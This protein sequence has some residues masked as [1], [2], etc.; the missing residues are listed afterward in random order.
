MCTLPPGDLKGPVV[1]FARRTAGALAGMF[2]L[3][4]P[5]QWFY[6]VERVTAVL[7]DKTCDPFSARKAID[8]YWVLGRISHF[9]FPG[10][11]Q[12]AFSHL[13][14]ARFVI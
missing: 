1:V 8:Q 3:E 2:P 9:E 5:E 6:F 11:C 4:L 7:F 10:P 14:A 13:T 12:G